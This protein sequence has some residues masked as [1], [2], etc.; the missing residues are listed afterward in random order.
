MKSRSSLPTVWSNLDKE[1]WRQVARE[2]AEGR[3]MGAPRPSEAKHIRWI[4]PSGES[5]SRAD[6]IE[7]ARTVAAKL[8]M[9]LGILE[10]ILEWRFKFEIALI[11]NSGFRSD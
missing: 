1:W 8:R 4:Q 2:V 6:W 5:E 11:E 3:V 9:D 10:G 7:E